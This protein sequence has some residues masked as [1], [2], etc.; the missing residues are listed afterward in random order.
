MPLTHRNAWLGLGVLLL[1]LL[2]WGSLTPHPPQGPR[3][4][5]ADKLGHGLAYGF[6]AWYFAQLLPLRWV[7]LGLFGYGWLLEG[8]QG[9]GGVRSYEWADLAAN[10]TGIGLGLLG[11]QGAAGRA[12]AWL[13][14][15]GGTWNSG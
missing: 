13:E 5:G 6:L 15:K 8:L 2:A 4:A 14:S 1:A 3:F 11:A 12:L 7:S 10:G 9:W